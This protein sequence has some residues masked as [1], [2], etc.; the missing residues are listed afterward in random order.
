VSIPTR[1]VVDQF[2]GFE[3]IELDAELWTEPEIQQ[4]RFGGPELH[5]GVSRKRSSGV[6]EV[7]KLRIQISRESLTRLLHE[8]RKVH[9]R[10]RAQIAEDLAALKVTA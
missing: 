1:R 7:T 6:T 9:E 4:N 2:D 5:I 8:I 3:K 10:E